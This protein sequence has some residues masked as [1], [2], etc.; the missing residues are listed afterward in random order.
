[1]KKALY[2]CVN[3]K[4]EIETDEQKKQTFDV[5]ITLLS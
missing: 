2:R 5:T 3:K 4:V 1:M